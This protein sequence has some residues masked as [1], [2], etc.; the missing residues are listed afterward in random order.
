MNWRTLGRNVLVFLWGALALPAY[1]ALLH[2]AGASP[3][4]MF[5]CLAILSGNISLW[6]FGRR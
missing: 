5:A 1:L 3:E 2:W 6:L 4:V